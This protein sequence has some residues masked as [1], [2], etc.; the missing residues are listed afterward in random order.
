MCVIIAK[1]SES[2]LNLNTKMAGFL[3]YLILLGVDQVTTL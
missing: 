2:Y 1:N 3:F